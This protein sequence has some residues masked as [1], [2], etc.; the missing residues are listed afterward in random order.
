MKEMKKNERKGNEATRRGEE[1]TKRKERPKS[2]QGFK[3]REERVR[4]ERNN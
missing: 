1:A 3:I 4:P 2:Q